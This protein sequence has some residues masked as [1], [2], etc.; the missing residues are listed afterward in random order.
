MCCPISIKAPFW[1]QKKSFLE[2]CI[3]NLAAI[4]IL[5]TLTKGF[6]KENTLKP[7][8]VQSTSIILDFEIFV[9]QNPKRTF[10]KNPKVMSRMRR[11]T[12]VNFINRIGFLSLLL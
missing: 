5:L 7:M 1:Y 6:L 10:F 8:M 12:F 9:S 11:K 3:E 2:F 4:K